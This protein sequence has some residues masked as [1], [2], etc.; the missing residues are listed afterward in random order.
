MNN[1]GTYI[2]KKFIPAQTTLDNALISENEYRT[3]HKQSIENPET[4]WGEIA[5]K[6]LSWFKKWDQIFIQ[7]GTCYEWFNGAKL[8][9]TYN[10]L[11]RHI[12][13]GLGDKIAYYYTNEGENERTITYSE[14]HKLV[15]KFANGLKS[16]GVKKAD[17]VTIYMPLTI[18]LTVAMLACARIGAV[19]SVVFGGFSAAALRSRIEDAESK[20]VITSVFTRRR[21]KETSLRNVVEEATNGLD[22]LEKII[23]DRRL[24]GQELKDREIDFYELLNANSEDCKPE[25]MDAED[26]L[27][28]L[29][30]SGS[31]GK[32]KGILHTVGGYNLYTHYTT[33]LTFDIHKDDVYWCTA[34]CGWITGH[35][36]VLYG[37]LSN[38]MTNV[39]FEGAPD[40]PNPEIWWA[41]I[42]KYKVT[43]FY[44]APTAIRM[45]MKHGAELPKKHNLSSLKI[46]GSVGEPINPEA[47]IWYYENIGYSKCPIVDTWW[48]TETGGHILVTLPSIAQKPGRAGLPFLGIDADVVNHEGES[49]PPGTQ[50]FLVI[51]KPWPAALRT[52]WKNEERFQ[53]YWT[54]IKEG[55]YFSGDIAIKDEDGYFT[56]LGRTD[57]V[58][59]V[60]GHRIGS[61]EVESA[62]VGHI[63][64]AEAAAVGLPDDVKGENIKVFV[65]L[66]SGIQATAELKTDL[67]NVVRQNIGGFAEPDE[68]EFVEKLPKTRSGKIMR[69]VLRATA[70]GQELG[71]ISTLEE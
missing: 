37:P 46:I 54:E 48:Q 63:A 30:T 10:C 7:D 29:Y 6:E 17:T 42:E 52:C 58:I 67:K 15:C 41:T 34:D 65:I 33:K 69:R 24:S 57:D 32:P 31:T 20:I 28:I 18:E 61:A 66:K 64:V 3:L 21:G 56:V 62:L 35:S 26:P 25:E 19:H 9:I 44:T 49:V 59:K 11:D 55:I 50:G 13:K 45:F 1:T 2:D 51:R 16:L 47:W 23:I 43:K 70:L 5:E 36:Y 8:N 22:F 39:I 60:S 68:I 14:L 40:F 71:D 12:E 27:F 53:Q 38:G 4:F